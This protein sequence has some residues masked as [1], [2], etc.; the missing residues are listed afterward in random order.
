MHYFD[1]FELDDKDYEKVYTF[2][3]RRKEVITYYNIEASFDIETT[4]IIDKTGDKQAFMYLWGFGIGN[5]KIYGR[6]WNDF[7]TIMKN[8]E[9]GLKLGSNRRLIV[10]VHNLAYEFQFFRKYFEWSEVFALDER[11]PAKAIT[12]SGVEFRCSYILSGYSLETIAKNLV[13][14]KIKKLVGDLDYSLIRHSKTEITQ[15]EMNYL[16]NDITIILYYIK[17]EIENNGN[18]ISK[19]VLTNTG[20]VRKYVKNNCFYTDK[21]HKKTSAGKFARYKNLMRELVLTPEQY[22]QLNKTFMGGF[23][24]SSSLYSNQLLENVTSIDFNSSYPGVMV[25]EKFPMSRPEPVKIE[26]IEQLEK[27]VESDEKGLMFTI[28]INNL[29]S[30]LT[31]ESYISESKCEVLEGGVVNNGRVFE[32]GILVTNITDIDYKIIKA[33]YTWD[34]IEISNCYQFYMQYL[35]RSILNSIIGLY[36]K[37]TRLKGV[38]GAEVEYQNSKGMLNSVYG[39]TVTDIAREEIYY[40]NN[41][42]SRGVVTEDRL[43][44]VIEQY[45]ISKTRFLYYPWGVWVTAYARKNVWSGILNIG[46][47]YVYS[48]TDSVKFLNYD[49]HVKYIS[50]YNK[51]LE[52]KLKKMCKFRQI[53]FNRLKPK[54]KEG[55]EKLIGIWDFDGEYS[56]FKTLGA[57]RYLVRDKKTGELQLTV[58]GLSKKNGVDYLKSIKQDYRDIF[59]YFDDNLYIPAEHTGKLT[60]TYIDTEFTAIITDYRGVKVKVEQLSSIHLEKCDFTLSISDKYIDFLNKMKNGYLY[61]GGGINEK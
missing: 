39:M 1:K 49:K 11:K 12:T 37:K 18:D 55:V 19:I 31:Y 45:N 14:H 29:H 33:V 4:S 7:K 21:N 42:W 28:K 8:L 13:K 48:D 24:H 22:K 44:E 38:V 16:N 6:T 56:H 61:L 20:R 2:D 54:T 10:Y 50:W 53:D 41:I 59:K 17:E 43:Y 27:I 35:P 36:E 15:E 9:L 46:K 52:E 60:H 26:T 30:K 34:S 58:A 5:K 23:T 51:N 3:N 40:D 25:S 32:A 47:D 57:K